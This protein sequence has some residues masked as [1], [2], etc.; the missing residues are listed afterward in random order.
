MKHPFLSVV[1]PVYNGEKY[2]ENILSAFD[3]QPL[4]RY[5]LIFVDDGSKDGSYEK[6][7]GWVGR[8]DYPIRV[9]RQENSGVSAARNTG[10][11]A[12]KG[13]YITFVDVDDFVTDDYLALLLDRMENSAPEVLVFQSF[14]IREDMPYAV[15]DNPA[16]EFLPVRGEEILNRFIANPTAFAVYN[17]VVRRELIEQYDL[18]FSVGYKYYE[19]YDYLIRVFS[20]SR[21]IEFTERMLYFYVLRSGSAMATF[22]PDRLSCQSLLENIKPFIRQNCPAFLPR[23]EKWMLA[24]INWS[25][26]WQACRAF[27]L[28]DLRRFAQRAQ[29]KQHM[30]Q[31]CDYPDQKVRFSARI[32]RICPMAYVLLVRLFSGNRTK[33][34]K[35]SAE[36]FWAYFDSVQGKKG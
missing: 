19:D 10:I 26:M 29:M 35:T 32:Y 20:V 15:P 30:R 27:S 22:V 28:R 33:V 17:L 14:R 12:A 31:L 24:R 5:E 7:S 23:Y 8:K 11:R 9:V 2:I 18:F 6:I 4:G 21:N 1:I 25:V 16:P 13:E 36:A 34:S 3:R